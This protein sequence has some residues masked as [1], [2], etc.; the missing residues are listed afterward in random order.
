LKGIAQ[1]VQLY[2]LK[3]SSGARKRSVAGPG[4]TPFTG[5][6]DELRMLL[7]LWDRAREG[8]GQTVLVTGEPGIGKSRLIRQFQQRIADHPHTWIESAGDQFAQSTPFHS[9]SEMLRGAIASARTENAELSIE[10]LGLLLEAAGLKA[11]QALRLIAPLLDLPVPNNYPRSPAAPEEQRRQLLSSLSSWAIGIAR[12]QPAVLLLDDLQW[13]DASTM[14]LVTLL[15]E[16]DAEAPLMQIYTARSGFDSSWLARP[17][18]TQLTLDRLSDREAL[19]MVESVASKKGLSPELVATVVQRATGI[20]LFVEE[21]TRDLLERGEHST[22]RAI[23]TTLRDLLMARLDRLGQA[24]ELAQIGAAIGR[25]FSHELLRMVANVSERELH[26]ALDKLV[27]ADLLHVGRLEPEKSYT[28]KHALVQDAAY[29]TLLKSR[30]R[31][32]H[33]RIA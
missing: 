20:P 6:E 27:S 1:P 13:A 22:P 16:H 25:E 32:L 26:L 31:E 14:E 15:V 30:R 4:F 18:H 8:E 7:S 3:Q 9:V 11:K 10:R 21:L 29:A 19:A 17:H 2:Q 12:T 23:P 33:E 24:R 5:R 28:F